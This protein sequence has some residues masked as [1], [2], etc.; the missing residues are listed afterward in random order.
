MTIIVFDM[1]FEYELLNT[2]SWLAFSLI[3]S[4]FICRYVFRGIENNKMKEAVGGSLMLTAQVSIIFILAI[5]S[6]LMVESNRLDNKRYDWI[7]TIL[8]GSQMSPHLQGRKMAVKVIYEEYGAAIPYPDESGV[9]KVFKPNERQILEFEKH[10]KHMSQNYSNHK[11]LYS[12]QY[13]ILGL[14]ASILVVM[15]LYFVYGLYT[16]SKTRKSM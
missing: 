10:N 7:S 4:I 8:I 9:Y 16:I 15:F 3:L 14:L 2:E 12:Y 11:S 13:K 6:L 1:W 5:T